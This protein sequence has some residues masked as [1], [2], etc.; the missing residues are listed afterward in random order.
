MCF[1]EFKISV[2]IVIPVT[3]DT[4]KETADVIKLRIL[5]RG[6]DPGL[7][8]WV[9]YNHKGLYKREAGDQSEE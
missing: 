1:I 8:R 9:Q 7:S 5:R 2:H 6:N 4:V 3:M